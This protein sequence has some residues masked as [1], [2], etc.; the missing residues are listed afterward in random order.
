MYR[1]HIRRAWFYRTAGQQLTAS[2]CN[3]ATALKPQC[4]AAQLIVN[5]AEDVNRVCKAM[6]C[7]VV[8]FIADD[9]DTEELASCWPAVC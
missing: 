8:S 6:V 2:G 3:L 5:M 1:G 9:V 4:T 7:A